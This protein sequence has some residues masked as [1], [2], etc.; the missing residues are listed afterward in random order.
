MARRSFPT[1][2]L[3]M[4]YQ[5]LGHIV[6]TRELDFERSSGEV[7]LALVMVGEPVQPTSD[8]PWYC[9]Y[10]IRT[11][12]FEKSYAIAG[13]DSMQALILTL[14][15][16]SSVLISLERQHGGQFKQY[17]GRDLG[18]PDAEKLPR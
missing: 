3:T 10:Q 1:L 18:F 14:H 13:E 6:A 8:G 12:S 7:E 17:G 16:L 2:D 5:P 15:V 4:P 11:T 9:P